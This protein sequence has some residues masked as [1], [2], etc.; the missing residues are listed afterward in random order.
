MSKYLIET[1][2][3]EKRVFIVEAHSPEEA[4]ELGKTQFPVDT[5]ELGEKVFSLRGMNE[6]EYNKDWKKQ[7]ECDKETLE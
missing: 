7:I 1:V 2:K 3:L 6:F 5:F 4:I